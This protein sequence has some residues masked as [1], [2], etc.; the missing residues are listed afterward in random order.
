MHFAKTASCAI[1]PSNAYS[2]LQKTTL[3]VITNQGKEKKKKKKRK[4]NET[5]REKARKE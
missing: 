1:P 3:W 2:R 4:N 5:G